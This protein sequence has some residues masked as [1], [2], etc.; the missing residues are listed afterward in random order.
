MKKL[1]F[2]IG[3]LSCTVFAQ[4]SMTVRGTSYMYVKNSFVFV[5]NGID[6]QTANNFIYLR[7]EGQLLQGRV[8]ANANLGLGRLSV[9]QEGTSGQY[10]YNYWCAPVGNTTATPTI[11][12]FGIT[13]A[14]R[15]TTNITSTA[16][17]ASVFNDHNGTANPLKISSRWIYTYDP[18]TTYSA[19]DY[20]GGANTI[21]PGRGF[22][23]KGTG[24]TDDAA[25]LV[26]A[27][28]ETIANNPGNA[29]RYDFRGR[30]NSGDIS[31]PVLAG[32]ETLTGN[33]Y[34]SAIDLK[35]FL[36]VADN[37]SAAN[38][39]GIAYFWEHDK[40]VL[41]HNLA[42]YK[43]GY[44]E[45]SPLLGPTVVPYGNM[46]VYQPAPF[47]S[48]DGSGNP[49]GVP[50]NPNNNYER[51]FCPVGQGFNIKGA[52]GIIGTQFVT[53]SDAFRVFQKE[54]AANYSQF[55]RTA[56]SDSEKVVNDTNTAGFLP[57][58]PSVSGFDYTTVSTAEV[59]QMR[60]NGMINNQ[61]VRQTT[62]VLMPGASDGV[63]HA[64]EA[65]S[66]DG[67][68][69]DYY[70]YLGDDKQYVINVI[71]FN[72]NKK[73]PLG[74]KNNATT[75]FKLTLNEMINFETPEVYVHDKIND[76]YT[77]ILNGIF[78]VNLPAGVNNDQYE[79]TFTNSTLAVNNNTTSNFTVFQNNDKE[80]LNIANPNKIEINNII[81]YDVVG[82]V[83]FDKKETSA[84]DSYQFSTSTYSDGV[85]IVKII[86]KDNK[87]FSQKVI[88]S[89]TK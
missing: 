88:I 25:A 54:G 45:Y 26:T 1:Y 34:P 47:Y 9:F 13:M 72:I 74:F 22:S 4:T 71:E 77:D 75:N 61:G 38:C 29:Q 12:D 21:P 3:L 18:G 8:G 65:E 39:N 32:Q 80:L 89:N 58:I 40:T 36:S 81:L 73:I 19:W 86:S 28:G 84:K 63:E 51:R 62:L 87:E 31:I 59:P 83:I 23:M 10:A 64:M 70:F 50:T 43:G 57:E 30:A 69:K 76:T 55:E 53:M 24:G 60:F 42:D 66:I 17:V 44:G 11:G 20:I 78:E 56:N 67:F 2:I 16:A 85:Y 35:K 48:Y 5:K 6:L 41:S 33:P 15:P 37:P 14:H 46:G 79:I 68:S 52:T 27:V 7:N 49:V 82:K